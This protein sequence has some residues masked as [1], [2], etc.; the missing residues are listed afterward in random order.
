VLYVPVNV[1][2]FVAKAIGRGADAILLDLED[3]IPPAEKAA[4]RTALPSAIEIVRQGTADIGVRINR[5]LDLAVRDIEVAVRPGV[6]FLAL[7]KVESADHICLLAELVDEMEIRNGVEPGTIGFLALVESASAL[8][9]LEEIAR[10]H[11]RM[12]VLTVGSE[13]LATDC[14]FEPTAES[15]LLPKQLGLVAARAAGL[16]P[17]GFIGS[18]AGFADE[19]AFRATIRRSRALGFTCGFAI[20]PSQVRILN[21]EFAPSATEVEHARELLKAN[22]E[23]AARDAGAFTFRGKMVDKPIVER[24]QRL[25]ARAAAIAA[26]GA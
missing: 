18:V 16:V 12:M 20:H 11:E 24:A 23:A 25:V 4:T 22:A 26:R 1:E 5:P 2:R 6:Q 21:E 10:A 9:R 15:L 13:D 19:E 8:L 3:S 7:P 14:E 17:L